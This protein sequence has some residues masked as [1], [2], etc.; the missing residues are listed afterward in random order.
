MRNLSNF[1]FDKSTKKPKKEFK[2]DYVKHQNLPLKYSIGSGPFCNASQDDCMPGYILKNKNSEGCWTG[3]KADC[4]FSIDEYKKTAGYKE[5]SERMGV[6]YA[7]S[8]IP[9]RFYVFGTAPFCSGS[10]CDAV[11]ARKWP[12]GTSKTAN[13]ATCL[14]GSK[15]IAIEPV[16]K[17]QFDKLDDLQEKCMASGIKY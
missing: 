14:T 2:K 1:N 13:G 3:E 4:V 5:L 9:S 8:N 6:E 17:Y 15:V 11:K 10:I 12:I 16:A 7:D